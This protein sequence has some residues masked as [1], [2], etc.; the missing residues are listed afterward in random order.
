LE[1]SRW[2][3][4]TALEHDEQVARWIE[5][6]EAKQIDADRLSAS[7]TGQ[8]GIVKSVA[9]EIGVNPK[10]AQRA[11]KVASLSPEAKDAVWATGLDTKPHR[12]VQ[13][14]KRGA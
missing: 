1:N 14:R 12:A 10:D 9:D 2:A 11:K 6:T 3:E 5:L 4:P 7:R 13:G 8:K